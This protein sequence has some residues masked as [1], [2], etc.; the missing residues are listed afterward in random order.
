MADDPPV[1]AY[2]DFTPLAFVSLRNFGCW[3]GADANLD[4]ATVCKK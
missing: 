1:A 3:S 2:A 4:L